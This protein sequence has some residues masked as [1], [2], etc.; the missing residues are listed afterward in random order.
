MY[1]ESVPYMSFANVL[2]TIEAAKRREERNIL[3]LN[4]LIERQRS[5]EANVSWGIREDEAMEF[6]VMMAELISVHR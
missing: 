2:R 6:D 1:Y 3:R 4:G 5:L